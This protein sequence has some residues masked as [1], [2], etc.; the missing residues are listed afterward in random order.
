MDDRY[1]GERHLRPEQQIEQLT[2]IVEKLETRTRSLENMLTQALKTMESMQSQLFAMGQQGMNTA[3][4]VTRIG[5]VLQI[6]TMQGPANNM[7]GQDANKEEPTLN[8]FFR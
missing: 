1:Y 6:P 3:V 5:E 4:M 8:S 2:S 7:V